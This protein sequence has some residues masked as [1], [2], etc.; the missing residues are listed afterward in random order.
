MKSFPQEPRLEVL[1]E[2]LSAST[3][4]S[5]TPREPAINFICQSITIYGDL[6]IKFRF[7]GSSKDAK[8]G[9]DEAKFPR[10]TRPQRSIC[11]K[12]WSKGKTGKAFY[13]DMIKVDKSFSTVSDREPTLVNAS[14]SATP[15]GIAITDQRPYCNSP[16]VSA[17]VDGS[18]G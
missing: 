14:T 11:V 4:G 2:R 18:G 16:R 12:S 10:T 6:C 17:K 9:T 8:K 7:P 13:P 1:N 15:D 5:N 3:T